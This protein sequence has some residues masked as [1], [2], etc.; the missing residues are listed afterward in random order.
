MEASKPFPSTQSPEMPFPQRTLG[1][2]PSIHCAD[3]FKERCCG[4]HVRPADSRLLCQGNWGTGEKGCSLQWRV[5]EPAWKPSCKAQGSDSE[6]I[7]QA[8][9]LRFTK[10]TFL[11]PYTQYVPVSWV[12][13]KTLLRSGHS[14][15]PD[16]D[17]QTSSANGL[18]ITSVPS[19][20][21]SVTASDELWG[22]CGPRGASFP[23]SALNTP[24][25]WK[26][27]SAEPKVVAAEGVVSFI[28]FS[29]KNIQDT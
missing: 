24:A 8:R 3:I 5:K 21:K 4:G 9:F 19:W 20:A 1:C 2:T 26:Q 12:S 17:Y 27:A 22:T 15:Q 7:S 13:P 16:K 18:Q 29:H 14:T 23:T 28:F 10:S 25:G 6:K 11:S